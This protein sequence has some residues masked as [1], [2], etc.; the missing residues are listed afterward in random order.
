MSNS[1]KVGLF[2]GPV[3]FLLILLWPQ[4]LLSTQGDAVIAVAL[5]MVTW[6]LTEAVSISDGPASP[7]FV[8][9]IRYYAYCRGRK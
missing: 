4:P 1:K 9:L 8:S 6:W 2:L 7:A 3:F 5:W